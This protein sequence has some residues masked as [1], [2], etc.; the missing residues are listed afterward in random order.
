MPALPNFAGPSYRIAGVFADRSINLY[1]QQIEQGPRAGSL[2]LK[3]IPGPRPFAN[4]GVGPIRGMWSNIATS[5]IVS[6]GTVFQL[7]ADGTKLSIGQLANDVT[8]VT[9][10][11]NGFQLAFAS[12]GQAFIAPGG[13][14]G[15]RPLVD[16]TGAPVLLKTI[17]FIDQYF[18]GNIPN[19]KTVRI[20]N[21]AP[22]GGV[23]DPGDEALK[24]SY[25]DNIQRTW[26]D[27]PGGEYIFLIGDETMEVWIDTG[28]L[29]P[30]QRVQGVVFPIGTDS[31]WSVA[32]AGGFRA[33]LWRGVVYGCQGFQPQRISDYGVEAAIKTYSTADCQ[34]AEGFAW[35]D[36]GHIF[37]ALSFPISGATWV[38]DLSTQMWHERLYYFNGAWG[39]YRPR[40]TCYAYGLQLVGDY[41]TNQIYS[42]DPTYFYD[43]NNQLLRRQRITPYIVDGMKNDRIDKLRV[44][45]ETGIG[46]NVPPNQLGY[47]PQLT[48][49]YSNDRGQTWS[50]EVQRT[51]GKAGDTLRR[52][53]YA[54][55]GANRVGF[56]SEL[57]FSDPC[58]SN[59]L[60]CYIE[61]SPSTYP[62]R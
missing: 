24:E 45:M 44:E 35:I 31:A 21:L 38:Y 37:Y 22:D 62:Q 23:W 33:W 16:T 60:N 26:V 29:F 34:S 1:S 18:V 48:L 56:V 19:T 11:S 10:A 57:T 50:N 5:Y 25:S 32:G 43:A 54:P 12:A 47:N 4:V 30:F 9:I 51:A 3:N 41:A 13:G 8:P 49:R 28:A 7:N 20:S 39:R 14:A 36:G 59:F 42:L 61:I 52:V 46:L 2:W 55:L 53:E 40:M 27:Y 15:V 6:G 17:A 58:P